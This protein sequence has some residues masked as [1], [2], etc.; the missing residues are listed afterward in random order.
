M[1]YLLSLYAV[2][3][4]CAVVFYPVVSGAENAKAGALPPC[5]ITG[6]VSSVQLVERSP[7]EDGTPSALSTTQTEISVIIKSRA[8]HYSHVNSK[9][10]C[11]TSPEEGKMTYKLCSPTPVKKGDQI[12]A[13][14]S[15]AAKGGSKNCLFDLVVLN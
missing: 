6:I 1:K 14:E 12:Q 5:D 11:T 7:W 15:S 3:F 9:D 10:V 2:F 4:A 8:P 13:T